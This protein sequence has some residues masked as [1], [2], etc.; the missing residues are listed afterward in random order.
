M[1][2]SSV[3]VTVDVS[4]I[5]DERPDF[6]EDVYEFNIPEDTSVNSRFPGILAND[7]DGGSNAVISYSANITGNEK[8]NK[9][10]TMIK[11]GCLCIS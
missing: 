5:N 10:E 6:T 1:H 8:V 3:V 2:N 11:S 4:D 9:P 7:A